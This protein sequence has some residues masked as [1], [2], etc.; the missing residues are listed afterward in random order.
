MSADFSSLSALRPSSGNRADADARRDVQLLA[1]DLEGRADRVQDLADLA[2]DVVDRPEILQD[3]D[4]LVAAHARHQIALADRGLQ[5]LGHGDQQIVADIVAEA[6][7][8]QLEA[9]E[10]EKG[11]REALAALAHRRQ[12]RSSCWANSERLGRPVSASWVA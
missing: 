8:D 4:E 1:A 9:V 7:I 2:A 3:Q 12:R 10:I 11:D 6:V 5:A